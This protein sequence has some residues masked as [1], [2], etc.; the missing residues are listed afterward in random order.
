MK[1]LNKKQL[2]ISYEAFNTTVKTKIAVLKPAFIDC[3][4]TI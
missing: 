4:I 3:K 1:S 2:F